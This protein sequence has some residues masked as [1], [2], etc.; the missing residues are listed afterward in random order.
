MAVALLHEI[1]GLLAL[2][3]PDDDPGQAADIAVETLLKGMGA[4]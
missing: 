1:V 3:F 4:S 2:Q